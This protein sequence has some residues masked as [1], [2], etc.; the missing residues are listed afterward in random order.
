MTKQTGLGHALFV[1]Q[2]DI[3]GDLQMANN[4]SGGPAPL[5]M[6]DITQSAMARLGG[7][8]NGNL[9]VTT[10]F[11]KVTDREHLVY[12]SLPTTD[13]IETYCCGTSIGKAAAS[14]VAKQINYD[15]NRANDG[16]FVLA[17]DGQSNGFGLEWGEL[18]TAGKRTDSA[19]TNGASFDYGA[20]VGTT[21]FGLQMYVHL[22]AFT[23]TSVTIKIQSSTDDGAGDA[24]ADVTGAT[25]SALTTPQAVRVQTGAAVSVERYLRVVTTGTFSN[26]VFVVNAVR[27]YTTTVF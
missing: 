17:V 6:T 9:A 3:S 16:M 23:G 10:F 7:L 20:G 2:Y 4:I 25:T 13:R 24:F 5:D 18:L 15:G 8:R 14:I 11:N 22:I 19:A 26:A 21:A 1:D 27:N 12:R